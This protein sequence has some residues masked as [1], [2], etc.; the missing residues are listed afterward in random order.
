MR[1]TADGML[2]E[3]FGPGG[4]TPGIVITNVSA[5]HDETTGFPADQ[6]FALALQPDG[7]VVQAGSASSPGERLALARYIVTDVPWTLAPDAFSFADGGRVAAGTQ[8]ISG[9]M[10]V[11]GLDEGT[12]VPVRV[13]NGEYAI[14]SSNAY[15]TGRGWVR[16]G[17]QINVRHT[18]GAECGAVTETCS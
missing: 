17:D 9:M 18:A 7:K 1:Y 4:E 8:V 3:T 12:A 11:T 15:V 14:N 13:S 16:N 2:D 6:A 10:T 5:L